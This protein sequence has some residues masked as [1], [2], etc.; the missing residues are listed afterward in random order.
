MKLLHCNDSQEGIGSNKILA[1]SITLLQ[2]I[3]SENFYQLLSKLKRRLIFTTSI[4]KTESYPN[5]LAT[6]G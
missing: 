6:V 1:T 4:L 2:F 5:I 3:G